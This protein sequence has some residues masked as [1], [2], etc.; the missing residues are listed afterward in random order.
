[1]TW[2]AE[3]DFLLARAMPE[4]ARWAQLRQS[5]RVSIVHATLRS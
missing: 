4:G 5:P 3:P 1:M 2:L